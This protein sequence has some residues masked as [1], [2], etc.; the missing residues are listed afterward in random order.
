MITALSPHKDCFNG[1]AVFRLRNFPDEVHLGKLANCF[2]GAAVFRL[3]NYW[4]S[5][6]VRKLLQS[7]QRGR[8]LSTAELPSISIIG[9]PA[10]AAST[11]P[12]SFDCGISLEC[13]IPAQVV[14]MLQRGRSLST[15]ELTACPSKGGTPPRFNGA[16]VF[17][18]RNYRHG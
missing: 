7:L 18:L 13:H 14:R 9:L 16:A 17:R 5:S 4:Q 12:Q 1:A 15:A 8:S 3:R 6:N 10:D 11:G 2:N